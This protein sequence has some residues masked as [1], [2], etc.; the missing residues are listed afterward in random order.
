MA[1]VWRPAK[2]VK[3]LSEQFPKP[4]PTQQYEKPIGPEKPEKVSG[5]EKVKSAIKKTVEYAAP[6][7]KS[8]GMRVAQNAERSSSRDSGMINIR[9]P[10]D[11]FSFQAPSYMMGMP[12][13]PERPAPAPR[14]K[15]RK[16]TAAP[17]RRQ[18]QSQRDAG[19]RELGGVPESVK[20]WMM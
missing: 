14:R 13:Q 18:P 15:K 3:P 7:I 20:K 12:G 4:K 6:K 16:K 19:W 2:A 17:A 9:P 8:A 10:D 11:M 5:K 1:R